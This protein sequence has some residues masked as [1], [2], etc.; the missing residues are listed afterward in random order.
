MLNGSEYLDLVSLASFTSV[1]PRSN[2]KPHLL[3]LTMASK[4]GTNHVAAA[5]AV[6]MLSEELGIMVLG[7]IRIRIYYGAVRPEKM[8]G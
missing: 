1:N 5:E 2:E 3:K 6:D 7:G 8:V 4:E